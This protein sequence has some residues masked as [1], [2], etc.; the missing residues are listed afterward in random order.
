MF[1]MKFFIPAAKDAAQE[2]EVYEGT[3]KFVSQQMG[4][5]LSPRR[6]YRLEFVHEGKAYTATVG[7]T[8]ERLDER[9]IAILLDTVRDLYFICTPNRGVLRGDPYLAGSSEI[10]SVEDF[11]A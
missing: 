3:R 6:I 5:K 11:N 4:A 1:D 9:V 7:E 2:K 10:R 8:F